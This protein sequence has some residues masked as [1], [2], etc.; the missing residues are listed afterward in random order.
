MK[1][2][3]CLSLLALSLTAGAQDAAKPPL[4]VN[5]MVRNELTGKPV[6][7]DFEWPDKAAIRRAGPGNFYLTVK[8]GTTETLTVGKDGYFDS[9]IR[10]NYEEEETTAF[11]DVR[12]KPGVPQ[13]LITIVNSETDETLKSAIDLF[14]MDESSIVFSEEVETSP[15][16][17]DLE[18]NQVH[19]LQV[20]RA[21][22][23]SFKDTIDYK[24]VFDGRSREKKIGLVPLKEGNRITLNNI[25]FKQ[26]SSDLTDFA[27]LML[28]ELSHVLARDKGLV[29]EVGAHTDDVGTNEY[30]TLLSEKRAMS[31]K[32]H[33]LEKGAKDAQLVAKGYGEGTPLVANDS[34]ENRGAN[35]RVEFRILKAN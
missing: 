10:V 33:L 35:R 30:N 20:R 18:Y 21:G 25:Y 27:K 22:F 8:P 5:I 31:V 13:L 34:E 26:G 3:I 15:Y 23:F 2:L 7:P 17:I 12:L 28:V 16:T 19:V 32:K 24:G 4:S 1:S 9:N 11:H 14:T 29:I 6:D